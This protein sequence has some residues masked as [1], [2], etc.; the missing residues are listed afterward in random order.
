VLLYIAGYPATRV[1]D[2]GYDLDLTERHVYGIL[3]DL[4]E[5]GYITRERRGRRVQFTIDERMPLRA[6]IARESSISQLLQ[7]LETRGDQ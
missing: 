6:E 7:L 3:R 1:R 2:I 4:A 5:G